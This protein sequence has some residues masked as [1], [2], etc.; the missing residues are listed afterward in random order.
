LPTGVARPTAKVSK[1]GGKGGEGRLAWVG[2]Q[3][4]GV[5]GVAVGLFARV[6]PWGTGIQLG[7]ELTRSVDRIVHPRGGD[8]RHEQAD[9]SEQHSHAE[10]FPRFRTE[11]LYA[12]ERPPGHKECPPELADELVEPVEK[13]AHVRI[14]KVLAMSLRVLYKKVLFSQYS[15]SDTGVAEQEAVH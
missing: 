14:L 11:R 8:G 6:A 5:V 12:P 9:G 1:P 2:L 4:G 10:R 13:F 15:E 7:G 3:G